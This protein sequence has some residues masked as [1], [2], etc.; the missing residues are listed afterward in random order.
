M[1]DVL[2]AYDTQLR[3]IRVVLQKAGPGRHH[4]RHRAAEIVIR[5]RSTT[6]L[7]ATRTLGAATRNLDMYVA[8]SS[9]MAAPTDDSLRNDAVIIDNDDITMEVIPGSTSV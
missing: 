4:K 1:P 8:L 7:T 5:M 9:A 2:L 3:C 6:Q